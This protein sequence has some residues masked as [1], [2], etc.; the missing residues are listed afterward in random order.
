MKKQDGDHRPASRRLFNR[1]AK[2][3]ALYKTLVTVTVFPE[4]R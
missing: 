1:V 2:S 4:I 3:D